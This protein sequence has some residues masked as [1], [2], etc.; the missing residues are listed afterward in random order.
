MAVNSEEILTTVIKNVTILR[1]R[2]LDKN[3]VGDGKLMDIVWYKWV[4]APLATF[5]TSKNLTINVKNYTIST[6]KGVKVKGFSARKNLNIEYLPINIYDLFPN[7]I[8]YKAINCSVKSLSIENFRNLLALEL[9]ALDNNQ[10]EGIPPGVFSDLGSLE[11]LNL[12]FNKIKFIDRDTFTNLNDL[13]ELYLTKNLIKSMD[14][15]LDSNLELRE[16]SVRNNSISYLPMNCFDQNTR[17]KRIWLDWNEIQDIPHRVF[18][19]LKKL[20]FLNLRNNSCI[21]D[22]YRVGEFKDMKKVLAHKC[23]ILATFFRGPAVKN[24]TL[25]FREISEKKSIFVKIKEYLKL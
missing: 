7:L 13:A 19:P 2:N 18:E 6:D 24:I 4:D 8:A 11:V 14:F 25:V 15:K 23:S 1:V 9:L 5:V 3:E 10:I 12:S 22:I 20:E 17:M 21:H 16:F